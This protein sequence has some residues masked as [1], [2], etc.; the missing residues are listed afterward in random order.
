MQAR[1]KSA[2]GKTS[3]MPAAML[4]AKASFKDANC[5]TINAHEEMPSNIP[6]PRMGF[7]IVPL[8]IKNPT[9]LAAINKSDMII[10][11][12][13]LPTPLRLS[14]FAAFLEGACAVSSV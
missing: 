3:E 12:M 13:F 1:V 10:T 11:V 14:C 7:L 6:K 2:A 5:V 8:L 4:V 9:T